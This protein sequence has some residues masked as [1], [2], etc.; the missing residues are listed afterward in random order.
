MTTPADLVT[1]PIRAPVRPKPMNLSGSACHQ[2][3]NWSGGIAGNRLPEVA[4]EHEAATEW[5]RQ[6]APGAHPYT[7]GQDHDP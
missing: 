2:A 6:I 1:P 4:A 3:R 5:R 7:R